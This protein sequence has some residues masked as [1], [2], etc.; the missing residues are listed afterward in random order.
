M[1]VDSDSLLPSSTM[2]FIKRKT[3]PIRISQ[4]EIANDLKIKDEFEYVANHTMCCI[5]QQLGNLNSHASDIFHEL[6]TETI[7]I[8]NRTKKMQTK[9]NVMKEEYTKFN[10]TKPGGKIKVTKIYIRRV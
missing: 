3:H 9:V 2:P 6:T 4:I 7:L 1:F 8:S 10:K 5:I